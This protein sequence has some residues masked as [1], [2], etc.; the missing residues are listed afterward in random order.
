MIYVEVKMEY[1]QNCSFLIW[2]GEIHECIKK[3]CYKCKKDIGGKQQ[4]LSFT[5][6][7]TELL[8]YLHYPDCLQPFKKQKE[9]MKRG[10]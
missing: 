4:Y 5:N 7:K 9:N 1:C 3:T 6:D 10:N 2:E 8:M